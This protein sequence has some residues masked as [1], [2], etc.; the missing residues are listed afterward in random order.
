MDEPSILDYLKS[1][2]QFGSK[3][4]IRLPK[5]EFVEPEPEI[6]T[7]L[8][9]KLP[10]RSL[11]AV[12]LS[13]IGQR[14]L[15]PANNNWTAGIV[16]YAF[17]LVFLIWAI[18]VSEWKIA[19]SREFEPQY[20]SFAI[21]LTALL[22]ASIFALTAFLSFGGNLF[23]G[24][25][26]TLWIL[27]IAFLVYAFR[28]KPSGTISIWEKFKLKLNPDSWRIRISGWHILIFLVIILVVFFRV[29]QLNGIPAEPFSDHAEKILDVYDV[30]QGQTHIFFPRNTG[31]EAIQMYLTVLVSVIFGTGLSF[32]S[33]K[34]GTVI[35]GLLTLPYVYKL[36][37]EFGNRRVALLAVILS[38][39]AYW[40]NVISRVGLRFPLYPLFAAPVIYYLVRGLRTSNRNDF[41]WAGL[42]LG[43]GLHGYSPFRIVP[44]LVVIGVA[45][46][47]LHKR[48][49]GFR[50]Q[51]IIFLGLLVITSLFVFLP[52]LHYWIENPGA[53]S[54][55]AFSRLG[56]VEQPISGAWWQVFLSNLLN[57]NGMFNWRDGQI[58]V[59]SVPNRPALDI[60]SGAFFILGIILLI[61]RYFKEHDWKDIFLLVSIQVLMLPSILSLAYPE[62][63]PAL[64]RAGA[65]FI[66]VFIIIALALDGLFQ[67]ISSIGSKKKGTVIA[68]FV[69]LSLLGVSIFQNYNLVFVQ[70][71]QEFR[72]SSWNSSEMGEVISQFRDAYGTTDTAWIVPYPY[73]V[74]TRLPGIWA[75][76]PNRDFAIFQDHISDTL[77]YTGTKLFIYNMN[78]EQTGDLL[79][80]IYPNGS[81]SM[82]ISSTPG[83]DFMVYLVPAQ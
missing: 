55:R 79:K 72:M 8:T 24:F 70:Y 65:A 25:N 56:G 62:E 9:G 58:W 82:Y 63:N 76:I 61:K 64:N 45:L 49:S 47:L 37:E 2:F 11:L 54:Y 36:G 15:E 41:I 19:P 4:K 18:R 60:V 34:I 30:T 42:F 3:N 22:P 14:F 53:F 17:A 20:D 75:G 46:F 73:W 44:I 74:D 39:I 10:W 35:C 83:H 80:E 5:M 29:S 31:R 51:S 27:G 66:P 33:L 16:F 52:L 38:G 43:F 81:A 78:D 6:E 40:P 7:P 21:R 26:V 50:Q 77:A 28:L 1:L 71:N 67:A 59:N 23:T 32:L 69:M 12:F 57:A 48:S 13:L 68:W